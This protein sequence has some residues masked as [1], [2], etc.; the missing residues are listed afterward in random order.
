MLRLF[1]RILLG[2]VALVVVGAVAV[3]F[4]SERRL[5]ARYP[6]APES[7]LVISTDSATI[8]RG[9]RLYLSV[10]AC[11]HCHGINADGGLD[12]APNPV[13]VMS[14][15]NLTRGKGG[16]IEARSTEQLEWAIRHGVRA[17]STSL[18]IMPS[19]AYAHLSDT[20]LAALIAY[21]RQATPVDRTPVPTGIGPMGRALL[22][23][24]KLTAQV[25]PLTPVHPPGGDSAADLGRYLANISGCHSC[26]NAALSGQ[27][28]PNEPFARNITPKA[29]GDWTEAQFTAALREGKRPDGTMLNRFMPW[30]RYNGMTDEEVRALWE[31]VKSFPPKETGMQ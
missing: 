13:L 14:P 19:D 3:Y 15:P 1:G 21:L 12:A 5:L 26:H 28:I 27:Q 22:A 8:D 30:E 10:A 24:G 2:L 29:I 20:D 17:D 6:V 23:A 7:P 16:I 4:L 25:A 11:A 9:R 18:I 31:Y